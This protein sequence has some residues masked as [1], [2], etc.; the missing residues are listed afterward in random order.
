MRQVVIFREA[1]RFAGWPANYGIWQW[2]DEIVVGFTVGA[3]D[4]QG[5]FHAR[6]RSKP[7][8]NVQ[9]RSTDSGHDWQIEPF[10]GRTPGGR[11]LSAD[12]HMQEGLGVGAEL[13]AEPPL[14]PP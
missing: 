11:G 14:L 2:D 6:D 3:H 7:F 5:G 12:E 1:G 10:V 13:H 9:A 4:S 8:V